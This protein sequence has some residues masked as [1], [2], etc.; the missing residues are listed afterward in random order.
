M[1]EDPSRCIGTACVLFPFSERKILF[2]LLGMGRFIPAAAAPRGYGKIFMPLHGF[3]AAQFIAPDMAHFRLFF[4]FF[5]RPAG[6][7]R[8]IRIV[9]ERK[10]FFQLRFV[11]AQHPHFLLAE[12]VN[13]DPEMPD[14]FSG[15]PVDTVQDDRRLEAEDPF[16]VHGRI[17]IGHAELVCH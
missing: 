1:A 3:E 15:V 4:P 8:L 16:T 2:D 7:F 17:G 12:V 9:D 10:P 13:I 6:D 11:A 5:R 14:R